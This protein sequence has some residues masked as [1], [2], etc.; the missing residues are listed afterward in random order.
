MDD[1]S[2]YVGTYAKYNNGSIDGAWVSLEGHD[3]ESFYEE[4]RELH[5]DEA[6]PE[7]MFQD[8]QN[9]PRDF[10]GESGLDNQIWEWLELDDDER[11]MVEMYYDAIGNGRN[12]TDAND[13]FVG[14]YDSEEDFAQQFSEETGGIPSDCPTWITSC[15]DWN[16]VWESELTH[17]FCT[18]TDDNNQVWV[19]RR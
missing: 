1:P 15:I 14:K 19:F 16:R 11:M 17:S 3:K 13:A 5:K 8:F 4:C 2:V 12:I 9:F 7:L 10:Y 6:D 18:S